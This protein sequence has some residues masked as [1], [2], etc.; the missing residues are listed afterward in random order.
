VLYLKV[1]NWVRVFI[2]IRD[3]GANGGFYTSL[4][5]NSHCSCLFLINTDLALPAEGCIL[6]ESCFNWL[7]ESQRGEEAAEVN[8]IWSSDAGGIAEIQIWEVQV[9]LK[10]P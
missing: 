9:G 1:S 3:A 7:H 4:H 5:Q 2:V 10:E 8:S 6:Q